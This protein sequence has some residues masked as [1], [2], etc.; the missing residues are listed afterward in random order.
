M[1]IFNRLKMT[2]FIFL[3]FSIVQCISQ[4]LYLDEFL[5]TKNFYQATSF[6]SDNF[7]GSSNFLKYFPNKMYTFG[8]SNQQQL[9]DNTSV[10][11]L[12]NLYSLQESLVIFYTSD[13]NEIQ[14][15][16]DFLVPQLSVRQRPKC[17]I[18]YSSENFYEKNEIDSIDALKYAW[19]KK[20]L[21][22]TVL[23]LTNLGDGKVELFS[24]IY[25]YN[26]FDDI[27]YKEDLEN[28][29]LEV[30]PDKLKYGCYGYP[31]FIPEWNYINNVT[32]VRKPGKSVEIIEGYLF[33]LNFIARSLDLSV[34][35]ITLTDH[36][37]Y[38]HSRLKVNFLEEF[39]LDVSGQW[40]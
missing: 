21:D 23:V 20:F 34:Q 33:H 17:L 13:L 24:L 29:N 8:V 36:K 3:G 32:Q 11:A 26:P 14:S 10:N 31:F 40:M 27:V 19:K 38:S 28:K 35:K 4:P 1:K 22:F 2:F 37:D 18:M 15:F 39:N 30:F 12:K 9:C 7:T 25:Y 6:I 5:K 16:I